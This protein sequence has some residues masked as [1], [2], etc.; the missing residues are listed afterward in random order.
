M[1]NHQKHNTKQSKQEEINKEETQEINDFKSFIKRGDLG[2]TLGITTKEPP[3]TA[4]ELRNLRYEDFG[5]ISE[6]PINYETFYYET[7]NKKINATTCKTCSKNSE[8]ELGSQYTPPTLELATGSTKTHIVNAI[9][10][11]AANTSKMKRIGQ[12][13]NAPLRKRIKSL[14]Q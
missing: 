12:T 13:Q 6:L 11:D 5:N 9:C 14:P 10:A 3:H 4:Q 2:K 1:D 7:R 8:V